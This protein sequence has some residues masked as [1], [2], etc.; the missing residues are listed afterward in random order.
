MSRSLLIIGGGPGG[1]ETALE[2]VKLG[3]DVTLVSAGP[4]GGT[5]LNEGCIPTKSLASAVEHLCASSPVSDSVMAELLAGKNEIVEKLGS[6]VESLMKGVKLVYGRATFCGKKEVLVTREDGST[7]VLSAEYIIIATGSVPAMLPVPGAELCL[8]SADILEMDT[9]PDRL[10]VIGGGVIGLEFASIYSSLGSKVTVVEY[11]PQLLPRF[12]TDMSK[13]LKAALQKRGIDIQLNASVQEIR[14]SPEGL[15]LVIS[16]ELAEQTVLADRVL[17]AVGRRPF[18]EGLC[19]EKAGVEIE[20]GAIAVGA[21]MGTSATDI[22]AAGDVTGG[23]MLAHVASAQG[24]LALKSICD[25]AGVENNLPVMNLSLVPA[26]VFTQPQ[27]ASIGLTEEDCRQRGLSVRILKSFYRANGKAVA[28][29]QGDG[30]C[31]IIADSSSAGIL[32]AH[33]LGA[34]APELIHEAAVLMNF[35]ITAHE[36]A[37][38]IHAHP[39]LSEILLAALR[40]Y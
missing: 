27:L 40:Q 6:G 15:Q 3:F 18:F 28:S 23:M 26:A 33:I 34:A 4:L 2:A 13:R 22:Y 8:T 35:G 21:D 24:L 29:G 11:C 17:M 20:R 39:S 37:T 31:K 9:V 5:C 32:G 16:S 36:A 19:L 38:V 30:Y 25:R 10:C 12:D 7:S 1:Y 14:R